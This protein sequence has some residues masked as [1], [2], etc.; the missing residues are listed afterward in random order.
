MVADLASYGENF[1]PSDAQ[2]RGKILGIG[3]FNFIGTLALSKLSAE[4]DDF[5]LI[6]LGAIGHICPTL[7]S[8]QWGDW[9]LP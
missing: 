8:L 3:L 5:A 9:K 7:K 4:K 2:A 1:I 6:G